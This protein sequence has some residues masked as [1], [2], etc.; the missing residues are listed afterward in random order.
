MKP[1][2][3]CPECNSFKIW[4]AKGKKYRCYDCKARFTKAP[5]R[6]PKTQITPKRDVFNEPMLNP[7][8]L[9][10]MLKKA[11]T[12]S[13]HGKRNTALI[14]TLIMT[15]A[16]VTE[17]VGD[18]ERA[19]EG[20]KKEQIELETIH[21]KVFVVFHNLLTLKKRGKY[22]YRERR[23]VPVLLEEY[24]CFYYFLWE[25]VKDLDGDAVLFNFSRFRAWQ[26]V[27]EVT[28]MFNHYFRHLLSTRLTK[29]GLSGADKQRIFGWADER[30]NAIYTHL[31]YKDVAKKM[32]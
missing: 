22:K 13:N 8:V 31:N 15:G 18:K 1:K 17:L 16:R 7:Q 21:G 30:P 32:I 26:I 11:Q 27:N 25:Y 23:S 5:E 24:G 9:V 2:K 29:K 28:G 4:K 12:Q 6:L 14:A 3:C 10:N 20:L 19:F